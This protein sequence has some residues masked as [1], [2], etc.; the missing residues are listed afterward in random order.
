MNDT[1]SSFSA[2]LY[3]YEVMVFD[4]NAILSVVHAILSP[5]AIPF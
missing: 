2:R 3:L 5:N 1:F 4:A